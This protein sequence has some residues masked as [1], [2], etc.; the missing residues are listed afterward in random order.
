MPHR[1]PKHMR[2]PWMPY[3]GHGGGDLCVGHNQQAKARHK[4][5][6]RAE[7]RAY[8]S[9][10]WRRIR[11]HVLRAE[12]DCRSCGLRATEVDHMRSR[13]AGGT[14]DTSNLHAIRLARLAGLAGD[15]DRSQ[16][17]VV[18]GSDK[19]HPSGRARMAEE[20]S[21]VSF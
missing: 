15:E 3:L 1:A 11:A 13:S 6:R 19:G 5:M 10:R 21:P 8:T 4:A 2:R 18:E 7:G 9:T 12:P 17:G 20:L 16:A 14:D